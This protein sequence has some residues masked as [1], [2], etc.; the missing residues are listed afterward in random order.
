[1]LTRTILAAALAAALSPAAGGTPN[2]AELAAVDRAADAYVDAVNAGS[3]AR[4]I[5][6][7]APDGV[8]VDVTRHIGGRDAIGRW[9]AAE[10]IGGKLRVIERRPHPGG[11]T[12]LVHW[13]PR[14]ESGWQALYRFEVDA[15]SGLI[16]EADLQ[17]AP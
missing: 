2:Q 14:G 4:L 13:A 10:V 3:L 12:L 6:S 1:M 5:A 16:R 7:F 9:A 15:D 8:V 11:T 17:Y